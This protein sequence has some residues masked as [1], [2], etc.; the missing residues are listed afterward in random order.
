MIRQCG[1]PSFFISLSA[2]EM[3][4]PELLQALGKV[5]HKTVYTNDDQIWI[6]I[7]KQH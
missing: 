2:A 6:G 3:K 5:L 4:W 7:Q 1:F